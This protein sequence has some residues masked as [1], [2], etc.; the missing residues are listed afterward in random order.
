MNEKNDF[1]LVPRAPRLLENAEPG[2]RRILSGMV[3]DTLALAKQNASLDTRPKILLVDD[4][5][6]L[7][8]MYREILV[9]GLPGGPEVRTAISGPRALAMLE[10]EP[11]QLLICDWRM[12]RMEGFQVLEIVRQKY[13]ALLT[14]V[15]TAQIDEQV[16]PRAY[17]LGV[18]QYWH[19]PATEEEVRL[20]LKGIQS[21]LERKSSR[22]P[23]K[24]PLRIVILDDEPLLQDSYRM[25]L[26]DW[27]EGV[28]IVQCHSGKEALAELS[29]A[30]PDLFITDWA[31]PEIGMRHGD[32]LE[33]LAEREA[34]FPVVLI[35]SELEFNIEPVV[36]SACQNLNF[37]YLPKPPDFA[38]MRE[39]VE[40]ALRIPAQREP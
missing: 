40:T 33:R 8:D 1:A 36:R 16:R 10:A 34:K 21:L 29:R 25:L 26:Q 39:V 9:G 28:V 18:D 2:A 35:T 31:H 17:A 12:P 3:A 13:P 14:V 23:G 30:D 24:R 11:F 6:D 38:R 7:L 4:D 27:Y 5:P 19:K 20:F 15:L 22:P 32:I 37:S